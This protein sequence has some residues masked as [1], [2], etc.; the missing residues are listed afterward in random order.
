[1]VKALNAQTRLL[2][3]PN[4]ARALHV[5]FSGVLFAWI[6][7]AAASSDHFCV[8]P[9]QA[10]TCFATRSIGPFAV[11]PAPF[12]EALVLQGSWRRVI[13]LKSNP[14]ERRSE[15]HNSHR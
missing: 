2:G 1:M 12:V 4:G 11:N 9:G 5:G 15:C 3:R 10:E 6:A 14:G 8:V 13:F 7:C